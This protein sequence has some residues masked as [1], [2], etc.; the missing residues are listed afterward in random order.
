MTIVEYR[1]ADGNPLD[2]VDL[3]VQQ[4]SESGVEARFVVAGMEAYHAL[5]RE[6]SIR[7]Q[8]GKG[9]FETYNHVPIVVDPFRSDSFCV[10][11]AARD[12]LEGVET[13]RT[14]DG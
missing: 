13:Y 3:Q 5:C 6:I 4:F 10:L 11:P 1:L 9:R 8:R 12:I 7:F 14:I 2:L